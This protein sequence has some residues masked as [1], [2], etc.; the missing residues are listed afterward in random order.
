MKH[1]IGN[2]LDHFDREY[3]KP[4]QTVLKVVC[5]WCNKTMGMKDGLGVSGISHSICPKCLK[6]IA[7]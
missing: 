3:I 2:V 7:G 1:N 4:V 5:S 6:E